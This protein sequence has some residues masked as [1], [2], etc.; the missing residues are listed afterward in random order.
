LLLL[1]LLVAALLPSK[2]V[3]EELELGI[4]RSRQEQ[5]EPE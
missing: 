5:Y 4:R 1:V 2:H 3:L